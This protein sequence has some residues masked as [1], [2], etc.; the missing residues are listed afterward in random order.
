[1]YQAETAPRYIRG[2]LIST[3]QLFITFG[4][5]LAS[6]INFGTFKHQTNKA[7][8]WRLPIGIGFIWA[9]ILGFGILL[10]PET[11]RFVYR[12]GDHEAAKRTMMKVYG[13]K[14]DNHYSIQYE[15]A[16]IDAK[17]NA[18]R[19]KGGMFDEWYRMFSAPKMGYRIALG[20]TLQMFQQLT[21]AN[22]FFCTSAQL[23]CRSWMTC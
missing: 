18:E 5:F 22:Y 8:S 6:C 4:I 3:Y 17:L 13:A 11:P 15:L 20:M 2:A 10:F 1:M 9:A 19:A 14:S 7:V 16:E 12:K 21:G 23:P